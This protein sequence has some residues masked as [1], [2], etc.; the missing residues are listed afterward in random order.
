[1]TLE[2]AIIGGAILLLGLLWFHVKGLDE[3]E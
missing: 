2:E 3:D 1:M